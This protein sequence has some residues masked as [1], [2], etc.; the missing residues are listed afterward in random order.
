MRISMI[1]T[2]YVGLV[3]AACFAEMGHRVVAADVN[4][5]KIDC[6][7]KGEL[8]IFEPELAG[9]LRQAV[10]NGNLTFVGDRKRAV[11]EAEAVF[12]AVGTPARHGDGKADLSFVR[13]ATREIA[14]TLSNGALV[15]LKSTVPVGTGD[16]V[17]QILR[18]LRPTLRAMVASNPEFLRAGSAVQD[19]KRPDR[20]V[21]GIEEEEAGARLAEIYGPL[22]LSSDRFVFTSRRS[23]ELIKYAGNA[24]LATKIAFIN[25]VADL[26]EKVGADIEDVSHGVGM[27]R[28]IGSD[29]L[30]PGPGFGG[31]CFPKDTLALVKMGH[32]E[33]SP[34]RVVEAVVSVNDARKSSLVRRVEAAIGD[35]VRGRTVAIL[36]LTFKPNTDDLRE[37]PSLS[38]I[39][40]LQDKGATVRAYDPVAMMR[41]KEMFPQV[42]F[43]ADAYSAATGSDAIVLMTEWDEF[44]NLNL[45]RIEKVMRNAVMIDLRNAVI[46][47]EASRVGFAYQGVGRC[48]KSNKPTAAPKIS[49]PTRATKSRNGRPATRVNGNG[50]LV[51]I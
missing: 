29:F 8:P 15:V 34:L 1:G 11:K 2:G 22:R 17:E 46:P 19:F 32:D 45:A 30:R 49:V 14:G 35:R 39:T 24:F 21:I 38:L 4:G 31:S 41:A 51:E 27:D 33:G 47:E 9:I 43:C 40:A 18:E 36:G 28:R 7:K 23:A 16:E 12:I 37:A 5:A 13:G 25:E 26:C 48:S 6:L 3:S 10:A 20:V 50:A 44:R 42:T